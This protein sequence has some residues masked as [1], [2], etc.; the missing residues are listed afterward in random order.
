[1]RVGL[2]SARKGLTIQRYKGLGEMNPQQL[3]DT[4]MDPD[5][6]MLLQVSIADSVQSDEIFTVLMGAQ[7]GQGGGEICILRVSLK[8]QSSNDL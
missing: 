1:M 2:E 6:R 4:T 5:K 8:G 3:W 7:V